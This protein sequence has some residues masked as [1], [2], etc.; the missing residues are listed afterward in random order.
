[1]TTNASRDASSDARALRYRIVL[2]EAV[3]I[4]SR[5]WFEEVEVSSVNG[6]TVLDVRVAD[7][8]ALHGILRRIHDLHLKLVSVERFD[9]C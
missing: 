9:G 2:E 8:S 3:G 6:Q 1:M 4:A 5:D 7:Q